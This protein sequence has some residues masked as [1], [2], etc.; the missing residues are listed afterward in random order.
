MRKYFFCFYV[1]IACYN[2]VNAQTWVALTSST[3]QNLSSV[4][5]LSKDT[6]FVAGASG[7]VLKTTNGGTTWTALTSPTTNNI[8][9][10][11]FLTKDSGFVLAGNLL[12]KT[13][14]GGSSW[15][16]LRS[17]ANAGT[18]SFLNSSIGFLRGTTYVWRTLNGGASWDSTIIASTGGNP[19]YEINF[20]S[21][22]VG[23][24]SQFG[25]NIYRTINAGATWTSFSAIGFS[26]PN[27]MLD[28]KFYNSNYGFV[29]AGNTSYYLVYTNN[30]GTTWTNTG[31]L[32]GI[33]G[34]NKILVSSVNKIFV[35]GT[36]QIYT[37]SDTGYSWSPMTISASSGLTDF[38]MVNDSIGYAVGNGGTIFKTLPG[39]LACP[40]VAPSTFFIGGI[41]SSSMILNWTN[42]NGAA[43]IVVACANS[44]T[45]VAPSYGVSY[46]A[47]STFGSGSQIGTG[48]YVVY[49]GTGSSCTVS[50]LNYLTAYYFRVYEYN[51]TGTNTN[52]LTSSFATNGAMTLLPVKLISFTAEEGKKIVNLNWQTASELNNDYFEIERSFDGLHFEVIGKAKGNGTTNAVHSYQFTDVSLLDYARSDKLDMTN[53]KPQTSNTL[54]YRLKQFDFDGK[55]EYTKIVSV[56][57]G[58]E[59]FNDV[60]II[61]NPSNGEFD[62]SLSNIISSIEVF[63]VVG[64]KI[65]SS[66]PNSNSTKINLSN[67]GKGIY[68]IKC[69]SE[70]SVI[71]KKIILE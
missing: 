29:L 12:Y 10:I 23:F 32:S 69:N 14:N 54:Y 56:Q 33:T 45:L 20:I 58:K 50:G 63:D 16:Y 65:Y 37:S 36:N 13:T 6:G 35:M 55:F 25:Y 4:Y 60:K 15:N 17:F 48:N 47:S 21:S 19:W 44:N 71:T 22:S 70:N 30:G 52:Y 61:P 39:A 7:T 68:F 53:T 18:M 62:V 59:T 41:T 31:Y 43:R 51:G 46:S 24:V 67:F 40:S 66:T 57:I 28:F 34:A 8:S 11:F 9:K 1:F 49:N 3:S 5:F 42:G 26:L 27:Q 38:F 2:F 64:N